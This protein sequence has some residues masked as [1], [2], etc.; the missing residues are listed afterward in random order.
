MRGSE[1]AS[2]EDDHDGDALRKI[3]VLYS[4]GLDS[5]TLVG[6]LVE[7]NYT[8]FPV[9]VSCKLPW[10]K[11]EK[12]WA[13][14]FLRSL[15]SNR[16]KPI[17]PIRLLLEGA[18]K[19]NW[20]QRGHTPNATSDDKEVFLPAR[21][22]LLTVKALLALSPKNVWEIAI[23]T[24]KGNPFPDA[25]PAYFH[26]MEKLLQKSFR[27]KIKVISPFRN[28]TKTQILRRYQQLP[29]Q[30]SFSCINPQGHIHCGVCNKCA[31]R[32]R[33]FL[34]AGL[35]DK[36]T[37]KNPIKPQFRPPKIDENEA[38]RRDS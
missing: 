33:A 20:S 18:Y 17:L 19:S 27:K 37:Y 14:R 25:T 11:T 9:Y 13:K 5:A 28:F 15:R 30:Y 34:L 12:Y 36:T 38:L 8:V 2:R 31:E 10:E 1:H 16:V 23:G 24:L 6:H 7:K 21:N 3:G 35:L 32:R 26:T 29:L 22:L 4:G